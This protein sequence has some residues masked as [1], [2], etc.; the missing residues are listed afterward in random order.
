[1]KCNYIKPI[2]YKIILLF[3]FFLLFKSFYKYD[4][5][6]YQ[7]FLTVMSPKEAFISQK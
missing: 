2:L 7:Y 3:W 4:L 5:S 1:M 6:K